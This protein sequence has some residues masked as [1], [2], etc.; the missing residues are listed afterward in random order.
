M[1]AAMP[2]TIRALSHIVLPVRDLDAALA[3]YRDTLGLKVVMRLDPDNEDAKGG[4]LSGLRIAGL[5]LPGGAMLELGEGISK[6]CESSSIIA[7]NVPD[8]TAAQRE[9]EAAGLKPSMPPTEV[10]P[11][12][13]MMFVNDPDGRTV[14]FVEF[15]SGASTS[16]ANLERQE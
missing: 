9:I 16:Y 2:V 10:M 14:E 4:I 11:G 1:L 5:L 8:I 7:L 12:I 13:K 6:N 15:A 3:F